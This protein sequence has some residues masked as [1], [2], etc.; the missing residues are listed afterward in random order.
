[1]RKAS[2]FPVAALAVMMM[3]MMTACEVNSGLEMDCSGINLTVSLSESEVQV[4]SSN[5]D[6]GYNENLLNSYY[7][8]FYPKDVTD[9]AP[10]LKGYV[11]G[12][13]RTDQ[14]STVVPA[15]SN[16]INN[17]LFATDNKCRLFVVAN[18]PASLEEALKGSPTL[19]QLRAMTVLSSLKSVPQSNFVMV[20]DGLVEVKSRSQELAVDAVAT[21]SRLACKFTVGAYV[22]PEITV[23]TKVILRSL[24]KGV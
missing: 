13:S 23:G 18:P 16:T 2:I 24:M 1:M 21:L 20:Y 14:H 19:A 7:Y 17:I 4:K 6:N 10:A 12:I 15:S 22:T 5:A 9:Q 3:M 8:F 11:A